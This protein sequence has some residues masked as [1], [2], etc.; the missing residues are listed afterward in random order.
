MTG[1]DDQPCDPDT[2][3]VRVGIRPAWWLVLL[4]Q[5]VLSIGWATMVP[6]DPVS[7]S[8]VYDLT[9]WNIAQGQ[10]YVMEDGRPTAYWPVGTSGVYAILFALF[11]HVF[12]PIV[13]FNILVRLATTVLVMTLADRWFGSSVA[14]LSGVLMSIWPSQIQ[15]TTVLASELPFALVMLLALW[16]WLME[17]RSIWGRAMVVGLILGLASYLRPTALL[18]PV[19]FAMIRLAQQGQIVKTTLATSLVFVCLGIT[20]APWA[21]RNTNTFD[22]FVLISTN[23]GTN[24]WMGNNPESDGTFMSPPKDM[25]DLNEAERDKELGRRAVEYIK[26]EP[27]AFIWRTVSKLIRLHDRETIGVHWNEKGLITRFGEG[28]LVPL[29][30]MAQT[31][32]LAILGLALAGVALLEI[33]LKSWPDR[34]RGLFHPTLLIWT[35]F[36][37]IHAV[38]VIQDRYHFPSQPFIAILAAVALSQGIGFVKSRRNADQNRVGMNNASPSE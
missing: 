34:F 32:W 36:A 4:L 30:I 7:D 2:G 27:G 10:G 18:L 29:K 38:I 9:A 20:V 26:A 22:Q 28:V 33:Q 14:L 23:G 21:Y 31:Y 11:G 3:S 15:F 16:I 1:K 17:D 6:V 35:Y 37:S 8:T 13:V 5:F 19:V 12:W 25:P 24:L